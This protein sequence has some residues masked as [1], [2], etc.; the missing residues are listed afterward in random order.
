MFSLCMFDYF[1]EDIGAVSSTLVSLFLGLYL[2]LRLFVRHF[3]KTIQREWRDIS[4]FEN[5]QKCLIVEFLRENSKKI[6]SE[7]SYA[8]IV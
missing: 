8:K 3:E 6:A 4:V 1:I 5:K 2:L 7:A